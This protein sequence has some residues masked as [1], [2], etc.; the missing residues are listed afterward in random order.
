M[1]QLVRYTAACKALAEAKATD[2]VQDI[3]NKAEAMRA[4][5]QQANN[6]QLE[7]DAAEIRIRAE[8]RLGQML[9]VQKETGGMAKAAPGNQH[10]GPV[11]LGDR[12]NP[13]TLKE[14]G[15]SKDLSSRAQK[16]AAVP[17]E[18]FE[19]MVGEWR[20]RI[21]E[22][23]ERVTVN[24][25]KEGER[26]QAMNGN[27]RTLGTGNDEWHTPEQYI[28]LARQAMG[29]IDLD[30]ASN[31][32]AQETVKALQWFG[33][34]DDGL[35]LDWFG[36]VWLNPPYSQPAVS[37]FVNKLVSEYE[38]GNLEA[39]VMLTNNATDTEWFHTAAGSASALLFTR[40]RIA[41]IDQLGDRTSPTHGNVFTYFG[42]APCRFLKTFKGMGIGW[43]L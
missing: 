35:S 3:R 39:A 37:D 29:T 11:G 16:L 41:F 9:T 27:V 2:E 33:I 18:Q 38:A 10:T 24:L 6:R 20:G 42:K 14:V 4:Y 21:A 43:K 19:G 13:P 25:L 36:K 34:E 22:E 30:P 31:E 32:E 5:A 7:T 1:T 12:S 28:E 8:R 17:E 40:G 26:Q 23:N 15:I